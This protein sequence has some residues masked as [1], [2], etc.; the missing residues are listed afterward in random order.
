MTYTKPLSSFF[1]VAAVTAL[2]VP[3]LAQEPVQWR[4]EDGG[5]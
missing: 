3:A 2:A 5:G 1:A 4:V